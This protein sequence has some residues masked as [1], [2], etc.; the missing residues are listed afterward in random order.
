MIYVSEIN[1]AVN[2]Y[3]LTDFFLDPIGIKAY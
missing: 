3:I 1:T 2:F